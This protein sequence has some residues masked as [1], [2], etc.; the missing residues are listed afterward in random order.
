MNRLDDFTHDVCI[1]AVFARLSFVSQSSLAGVF[2]APSKDG[3]VACTREILE[4]SC[5]FFLIGKSP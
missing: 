1:V 3:V 2:P 5:S 4:F